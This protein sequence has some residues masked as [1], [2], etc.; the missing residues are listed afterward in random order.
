MESKNEVGKKNG[1]CCF[2]VHRIC[3]DRSEPVAIYYCYILCLLSMVSGFVLILP[4]FR[5][6][7]GE[8][9]HSVIRT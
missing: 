5:F 7:D 6:G 4:P 1:D 2:N 8:M 3:I 9:S